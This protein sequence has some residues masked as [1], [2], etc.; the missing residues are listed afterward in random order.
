MEEAQFFNKTKNDLTQIK[1][2]AGRFILRTDEVE[3]L[4]GIDAMIGKTDW[5]TVGISPEEFK[6]VFET[7]RAFLDY[8][9]QHKKD[10]YEASTQ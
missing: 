1:E 7:A 5:E 9:D 2:I 8:W 4:G 3:T 10:I 6:L